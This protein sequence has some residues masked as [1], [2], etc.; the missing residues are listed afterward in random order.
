[1][2]CLPFA[3]WR[4]FDCVLEYAIGQILP[5]DR[6]GDRLDRPPSGQRIGPA[7][8]PAG[9]EPPCRARTCARSGAL[10]DFLGAAVAG[11]GRPRDG[12]RA[13]PGGLLARRSGC[14]CRRS[15]A[16]SGLALFF[17]L[18][19][20]AMV[21][22]VLLRPPSRIDGLRRLDRNS[23][24]AHRPATA[25][26]DENAT[27]TDGRL[28]RAVAGAYRARAAG[29]EEGCGPAR[30]RRGLR[31]HD[32]VALRAL[33]L[34]L[35]VATL[36]RGRQRPHA[37]H[38][39]RVRLAGRDGARELPRRRLGQSAAV[40]RQGPDHPARPAFRRDS[41]DRRDARGADRQHAGHPRD[42]V[43]ASTSRRPAASKSPSP[44]CAERDQRRHRG[45][46]LHHH[47]SR[48]RHLAQCRRQRRDMAVYRHSRPAADDLARQGSGGA[49]ARRAL[50][51]L[52]ARRRL[53]RHRRAG[54]VRTEEG[55]RHQ[56]PAAALPV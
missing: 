20:A 7:V 12:G 23:G 50:A 49:D 3:R 34:V 52:Q 41:A 6:G 1:M 37:P 32:P 24:R 51:F 11:D 33:V 9:A 26:S 47:R 25:I 10:V 18:A 28:G 53:R 22:L 17:L 5:A 15:G 39:R 30:R 44:D 46:P 45:A 35:L 13:V 38:R 8:P 21:P 19:A 27:T 29:R 2:G 4:G 48:R 42:R 55:R 54:A 40:Y 43:L 36:L 31:R 14:G 16:R 56:R